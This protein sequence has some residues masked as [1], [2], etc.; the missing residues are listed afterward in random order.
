MMRAEQ[1]IRGAHA[2]SRARRGASPRRAAGT[3]GQTINFH[4]LLSEKVLAGEGACTSTRGRVRSPI[5]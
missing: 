1:N 3:D 5:L 2:L 4:S